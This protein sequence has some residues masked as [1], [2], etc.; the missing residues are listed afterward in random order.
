MLIS[1][2]LIVAVLVTFAGLTEAVAA[3][4]V[5]TLSA[6][7][8]R[9]GINP[10]KAPTAAVLRHISKLEQNVV[11]VLRKISDRLRAAPTGASAEDIDKAY[12]ELNKFKGRILDDNRRLQYKEGEGVQSLEAF[13]Q[14]YSKV[15]QSDQE[16]ADWR[17]VLHR[18]SSTLEDSD[19]VLDIIKPL[20]F[21]FKSLDASS[22][23]T[24]QTVANSHYLIEPL[25]GQY[26]MPSRGGATVP[27]SRPV[28]TSLSLVSKSTGELDSAIKNACNAAA[29][30]MKKPDVF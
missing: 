22:I 13:V 17:N 3:A 1:P 12:A 20:G 19:V 26:K 7:D 11:L 25:L 15:K 5:G 23:L 21:D 4:P 8:S 30:Y 29:A 24:L 2:R 18:I 27:K 14:K 10:Q 28:L 9:W 16:Y 6:D